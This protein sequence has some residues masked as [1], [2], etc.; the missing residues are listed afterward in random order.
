MFGGVIALVGS[1]MTWASFSLLFSFLSK[2]GVELGYGLASALLG[3]VV[4]STGL[5]E[6]TVRDGD[7]IVDA[8]APIGILV[9]AVVAAAALPGGLP[10]LEFQDYRLGLVA[11]AIGGG[12]ACLGVALP[13][14]R[15]HT[16]VDVSYVYRNRA[17]PASRVGG[18]LWNGPAS[19]GLQPGISGSAGPFRGG[20]AASGPGTPSAGEGLNGASMSRSRAARATSASVARRTQSTRSRLTSN[21]AAS[22]QRASPSNA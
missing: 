13:R 18:T 11:T 3:V 14:R 6:R 7:P 20:H 17:F 21:T 22:S 8:L 1:F 15:L 9:V 12:L 19:I 16:P 5:R 10:G 4:L 2:S